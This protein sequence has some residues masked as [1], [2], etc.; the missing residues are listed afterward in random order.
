MR[1]GKLL[2]V[3]TLALFAGVVMIAI[4]T[5]TIVN[6][7]SVQLGSLPIVASLELRATNLDIKSS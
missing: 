7:E 4:S 2:R 3:K 5:Y 1:L 6:R